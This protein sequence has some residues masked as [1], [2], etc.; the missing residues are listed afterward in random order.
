MTPLE[1]RKQLLLVESDLNR[2]QLLEEWQTAGAQVRGL[3]GRA[4]TF[5]AM[6]AA[7]AS[8]L[9]ALGS[10]WSAP[11]APAAVKPSW[12]ATIFKG[13]DLWSVIGP[14]FG[15]CQRDRSGE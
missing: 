9:A 11:P 13:I 15:W 6:A 10:W 3:A 14:A 2:A 4:S 1:S 12:L 7:A 8:L 5:T